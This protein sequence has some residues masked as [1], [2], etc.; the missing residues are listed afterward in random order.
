MDFAQFWQELTAHPDFWGF[1]TIPITAAVVTWIHVWMAMQMVFYPLQF[2]GKPPFLGWQGII[3]RK[4]KKM[5]GIVVDKSLSKLGS[6]DEFFAEMQPEKIAMH[7]AKAVSGRVE[8]FTDEIMAERNPVLWENLPM[9]VKQRVYSRVRKQIP[10]VMDDLL[11]QMRGNINDLVDI[12]ALVVKLLDGDKELIVRM[13][14]EVGQNE[15]D[16]VVNVSFWIGL[17]FG[18]LQMILFYFVP[19]HG[20]LPLYAAVLGL[21]TNWIALNMVFRPL[22][23]VKIGPWKLQ[24]VFLKR[25][26]AVADTY[27]KLT[28][29]EML[30]VGN[31][32]REILTGDRAHRTHALIKRAMS[33]LVDSVPV[34]TAAQMTMGPT[35]YAQL[36]NT[37]AEKAAMMSLDPLSEPAFN[38]ERS[39]VLEKIL[40][41]RM[42]AL[43]SSEFQDLLRPAFQE[44]EWIF[45]VLGAVTGLFAG[46]IQLMLGFA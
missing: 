17:G 23:P 28:T 7:L 45:L 15:I 5:A 27:A 13:F 31:I 25:Q 36:R 20:G 24:G 22:N 26:A 38:K 43:S 12:K 46:T 35:G 39:L 44:D 11:K 14:K 30:T 10:E 29:T 33:P 2:W 37:I 21:A 1:V 42:K 41:D 19:W 16:F 32:M 8:E 40:S 4:A 3:P 34:R 18:V 6:M 9:I